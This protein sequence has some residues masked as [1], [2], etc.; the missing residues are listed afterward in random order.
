M[1]ALPA[2]V[3]T[4]DQCKGSCVVLAVDKEVA[5]AMATKTGWGRTK[6]GHDVCGLHPELHV[7]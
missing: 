2:I 3:V 7:K 1:T 6:Y 5:R 4:C